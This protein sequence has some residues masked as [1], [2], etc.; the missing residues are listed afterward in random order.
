[1]KARNTPWILGLLLIASVSN[2]AYSF[3]DEADMKA[4]YAPIAIAGFQPGKDVDERDTWLS[5]AFEETLCTRLRRVSGLVVMP[6]VRAY[7][8]RRELKESGTK[9]TDWEHVLAK[10]GAKQRISGTVSGS[11][12]AC[13]LELTV[14]AAQGEPRKHAFGPG[15]LFAVLDQATAWLIEQFPDATIDAEQRARLLAAP[16]DTPSVLEYYAKAVLAARQ[17][18]ARNAAYYLDRALQYD[19]VP[20]GAQLMMAQIELKLSPQSRVTAAARLRHVQELARKQHNRRIEIEIELVQSTILMMAGSYDSALMRLGRARDIARELGDVYGELGV[21][22][23]M[24]DV[25]LQ[26]EAQ[27]DRSVASDDVEAFRTEQLHKAAAALEQVLALLV[28]LGDQVASSPTTNKLALIYERL[29]DGDKALA[30]HKRTLAT[31]KQL[32]ATQMQ[33]T[34]LM[35]LGQFQKRQGKYDE[36]KAALEECA[37]LANPETRPK[38]RIALADVLSDQG[39]MAGAA[40]E[41]E[42]AYKALFDTDDLPNQLLCLERLAKLREASGDRDGA[43]KALADAIDIAQVLELPR[44][45]D[46][47]EKLAELG[48]AP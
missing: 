23:A 19:T 39:D 29:G 42:A 2:A 20:L 10:L 18:D 5:T 25:H 47:R 37:S 9:A 31:A 26:R 17:D 4:S 13:R 38:V 12:G 8:G 36:A 15:K 22:N 41:Y 7:L 45:K 32:G 48:G 21:L 6:T 34:A 35:F 30:M 1:M 16:G 46:L 28:K 43:R 40:R 33:A 14:S 3:A 27:P 11:P 24:G 44:E